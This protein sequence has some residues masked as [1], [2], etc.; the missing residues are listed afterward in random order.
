[1][2]RDKK[3]AFVKGKINLV[4]DRLK[5]FNFCLEIIEYKNNKEISV[6]TF[7]LKVF[8]DRQLGHAGIDVVRPLLKQ[9]SLGEILHNQTVLIQHASIP[10]PLQVPNLLFFL[11]YLVYN[12]TFMFLLVNQQ[13]PHWDI[14]FIKAGPFFFAPRYPQNLERC[15]PQSR[16]LKKYFRSSIQI[17]K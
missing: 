10:H 12:S 16:K 11:L 13:S 17:R 9:N 4:T 6:L 8:E 15:L 5:Y 3:Q 1:M 7:F 2:L 14:S